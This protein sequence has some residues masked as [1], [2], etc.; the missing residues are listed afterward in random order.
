MGQYFK[1]SAPRLRR[2][3][4]NGGKLREMLFGGAAKALVHVLAVPIEPQLPSSSSLDSTL[5]PTEPKYSPPAID[6]VTS[7][8]AKDPPT[9]VHSRPG[10][11]Q[12]NDEAPSQ[13]VKK[14]E[15]TTSSDFDKGA[16]ASFLTTFPS[17]P[18]ELH[19]LIFAHLDSI[20]DLICLSVTS[21][22]FWVIGY[23]HIQQYYTSLL[24]RWAGHNIICIGDYVDAGDY[25]PHLFPAEEEQELNQMKV[26]FDRNCLD[27]SAGSDTSAD[28]QP[29]TLYHL[30]IEPIGTIEEVVDLYQTSTRTLHACMRRCRSSKRLSDF[31]HPELVM[32]NS[33]YFPA[34]Q[35]W[36]LRNLTT[37][38]FVLPT[39]VALK[40]EYINGPFIHGLGFGEVVMARTCWTSDYGVAMSCGAD[41]C[42]G[43]WAGHRFDITT[44]SRHDEETMG[45]EWRDVSEDVSKEI[46]HIWEC[47]DG[48]DWR[49]IIHNTISALERGDDSDSCVSDD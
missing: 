2:A 22:Y 28:A 11:R 14:L 46:A 27:S 42:R 39:A 21:R 25:P 44:L 32:R 47:E 4:G 17:L 29:L 16:K 23:K 49:E 48:P 20:E 34:S 12:A 10:K 45:E 26:G 37:H 9:V 1:I 24:G 38:E 36:I 7:G 15:T 18:P 13:R 5:V 41:I 30:A 6:V 43:V 19:E 33:T 8:P 40:P 35:T 3:L 31:K